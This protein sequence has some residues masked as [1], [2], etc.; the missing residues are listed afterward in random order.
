MVICIFSRVKFGAA[1]NNTSASAVYQESLHA[2][3]CCDALF[4]KQTSL[5]AS[6]K[7][8]K[9]AFHA[10]LPTVAI[11]RQIGDFRSDWLP[12]K[13][14]W[15]LATRLAIFAFQ[16]ATRLAILVLQIADCSS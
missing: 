7:T 16:L 4:G 15:R 12:K 8:L 6:L 1:G 10:V 11:L 14:G 9:L 13:C 2:S 3:Q 5:P